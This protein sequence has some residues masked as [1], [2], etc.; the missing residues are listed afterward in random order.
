MFDGAATSGTLPAY[1]LSHLIISLLSVS[2]ELLFLFDVHNF[3]QCSRS[4]VRKCVVEIKMLQA[5]G[6]I[7]E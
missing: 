2:R 6:F 5:I 3:K 4:A 1:F 7:S